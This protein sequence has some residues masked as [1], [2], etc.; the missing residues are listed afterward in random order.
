MLVYFGNYKD[1][2]GAYQIAEKLCFWAPKTKDEFGNEEFP[3]WVEKFGDW[4]SETWVNTLCQWIDEKKKRI[5]YVHIDKYDTWSMDSTLAPI[6]LPLLKQL[7][8]TKHGAPHVDDEDVPE[9][10]RSTNAPEKEH[11]YDVDEFHFQRW[12]YILDEM[13]W[14]FEQYTGEWENQFYTGTIDI[15]TEE[16]E[17]SG[18]LKM[19]HGPNHTSVFD[20]EGYMKHLDRIKNGFRLFGKYYMALWD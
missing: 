5:E 17:E 4:L 9:I 20:S 7:Q 8:A 12:D 14:A 10:W 11:D 3:G 13:I 6:I 15:S 16:D 2:I 18:H 1:F 19:V